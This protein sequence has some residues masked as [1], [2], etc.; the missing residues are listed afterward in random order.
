M[1]HAPKQPY[2][3]LVLLVLF[4]Y[5][6]LLITNIIGD[7]PFLCKLWTSNIKFR[8]ISVIS[9]EIC[10]F[11]SRLHSVTASLHSATLAYITMLTKVIYVIILHGAP[12]R[13]FGN[14]IERTVYLNN[15][16]VVCAI[17]YRKKLSRK[18]INRQK[19]KILL[20]KIRYDSLLNPEKWS[21][22]R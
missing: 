12:C 10:L 11:C 2:E 16:S 1:Q 6:E 4:F 20:F 17:P 9:G 21:G 22:E 14:F 19:A 18:K 15:I 3:S 13:R 8:N 7:Q 5:K